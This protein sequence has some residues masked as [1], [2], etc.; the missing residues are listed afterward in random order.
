MLSSL[1]D[2]DKVESLFIVEAAKYSD[3]KPRFD[4]KDEDREV[5][6]DSSRMAVCTPKR[7]LISLQPSLLEMP[8]DEGVG[9]LVGNCI[10]AEVIEAEV[11]LHV[12]LNWA[13]DFVV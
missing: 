5:E 7:L 2:V 8:G 10:V 12:Y 13:R 1:S 11:V 3:S 9:S 4:C 6:C